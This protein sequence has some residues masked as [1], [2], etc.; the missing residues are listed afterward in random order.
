MR[1]ADAARR[2]IQTAP[3]GGYTRAP[4]PGLMTERGTL[5]WGREGCLG[6]PAGPDAAAA[7]QPFAHM[8]GHADP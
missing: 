8:Y 4:S 2:G 3:N 7:L 6:S 1:P 5:V